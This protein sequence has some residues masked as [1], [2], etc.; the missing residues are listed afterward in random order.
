[1]KHND[2]FAQHL[3]Q[4]NLING[5]IDELNFI[6][7][8]N[9]PDVTSEFDKNSI[10]HSPEIFEINQLLSEIECEYIK[11]IASPFMRESMT[12][13]PKTGQHVKDEIRTS[14]SATI[15][16]LTEDPAINLIM[17]KCCNNFAVDA[18]QSEVLHVLHYS[19]GEEYKPHYD[20]FG[21]TAEHNNFTE[22]QQ[23]IKTICLYLNDVKAG[24][25]TSFPNLNQSVSPKKGNAVF[26][27]NI[28]P[29]NNEPYTDSLH[30]G[31]P[32]IQGEKW[33]AT[34]WIRNHETKRGMNYESI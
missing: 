7:S 29:E 6:Q 15:D 10:N 31:E 5:K 22:D 13:D 16:W 24:G 25:N 21:G 34:L 8:F 19:I 9:W 3:R 20:F 28:N 30:A 27:E 17:Q 18:N 11:Y 4:Q 32:I 23:R 26:F 14:Y 12:V 33:L 1:L 2:R